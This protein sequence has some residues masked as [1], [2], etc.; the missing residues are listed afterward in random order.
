[1]QVAGMR[2]LR[3]II[4]ASR[5]DRISNESFRGSLG[6]TDIRD[7]M[8]ERRLSCFFCLCD[9]TEREGPDAGFSG[10]ESRCLTGQG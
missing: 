6:M 1:M 3:C 7:K 9:E 2:M 5:S 8:R 10:V 4:G